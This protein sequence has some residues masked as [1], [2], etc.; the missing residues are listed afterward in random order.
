MKFL[1]K[2][3]GKKKPRTDGPGKKTRTVRSLLAVRTGKGVQEM[4]EKQAAGRRRYNHIII[5]GQTAA[6]SPAYKRTELALVEEIAAEL[7]F[8]GRVNTFNGDDL[9][10]PKSEPSISGR[11]MTLRMRL[12]VGPVQEYDVEFCEKNGVS[13]MIAYM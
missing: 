8:S 11:V 9:P 7:D 12:G 1:D 6:A 5:V 2:L 3:F 4:G 10:D 13:F